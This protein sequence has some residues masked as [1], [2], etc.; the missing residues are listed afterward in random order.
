[1]NR[2]TALVGAVGVAAI[3]ASCGNALTPDGSAFLQVTNLRTEWIDSATNEYVAC[4]NVFGAVASTNRTAVAINFSTSGTVQS[5]DIG[6]RGQTKPDYDSNYNT[7]TANT[8][9][10]SLGNGTYKTTFYAD[11]AQGLLPQSIVVAPA[12]VPIKLVK[13]TTQASGSFYATLT[14]YSTTGSSAITDT[15]I[16]LIRNVKVYASCDYVGTTGSTL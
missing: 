13:P 14:V 4:D 2:L 3:L 11:S 1:M 6:L 16:A 7:N 12:N 10:T 9:L 8:G 15:R 5:A